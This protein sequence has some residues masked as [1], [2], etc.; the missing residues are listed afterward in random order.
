MGNPSNAAAHFDRD[1][2][3]AASPT[4]FLTQPRMF[5]L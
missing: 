4:E 5:S 3:Q 2:A 1:R